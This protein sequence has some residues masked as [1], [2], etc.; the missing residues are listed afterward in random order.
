MATEQASI[1]TKH[2]IDKF[3]HY[4][5]AQDHQTVCGTP[6]CHGHLNKY[7]L[8]DKFACCLPPSHFV[9]PRASNLCS[10]CASLNDSSYRSRVQKRRQAGLLSSPGSEAS[11]H[12]DD[13][14]LV[15][16]SE[17]S[18]GSRPHSREASTSRDSCPSNPPHDTSTHSRGYGQEEVPKASRKRKASLGPRIERVDPDPHGSRKSPKGRSQ[19]LGAT[20]KLG[21]AWEALPLALSCLG[22]M[23]VRQSPWWRWLMQST[24]PSQ[25][26]SPYPSSHGSRIQPS[27]GP[28]HPP[29]PPSWPRVPGKLED[30]RGSPP[31]FHYPHTPLTTPTLDQT[32]PT[33]GHPFPPCFGWEDR[34]YHGGF[35]W[36]GFGP[37]GPPPPPPFFRPGW[38]A[39]QH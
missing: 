24:T 18:G 3:N 6:G 29:P 22:C 32:P 2:S 34:T 39:G 19:D 37:W 1:N 9:M 36:G 10:F 33:G 23:A 38:S 8:H 15:A 20:H 14:E 16:S 35:E 11:S 25:M 5:S 7:D 13:I 27:P 28:F 21:L 12:Q 31:G 26:F 17:A 30:G 4:G